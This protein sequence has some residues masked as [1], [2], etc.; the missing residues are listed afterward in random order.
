[1][2]AYLATRLLRAL[3]ALAERHVDLTGPVALGLPSE[4]GDKTRRERGAPPCVDGR[5]SADAYLAALHK[6]GSTTPQAP[7]THHHGDDAEPS[8]ASP[9]PPAGRDRAPPKSSQD[10]R[11]SS[12][13]QGR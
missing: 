6:P 4:A 12:R 11:A 10:V 1:M 8:H 7:G 13:R 3:E 5:R 9:E 2:A